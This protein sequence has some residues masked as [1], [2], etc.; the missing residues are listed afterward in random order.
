MED[1]CLFCKIA[2]KEISSDV[3]YEDD[4]I[5]AFNDI[6]PQAPVHIIFIPK[7]H[8][9]TLN[10]IS[11][12]DSDL[13]GRI[14]LAIKKIAFKKGISEDGYRIVANCNSN[15]GQEVFHVH[16]HLLGGRRCLWPPG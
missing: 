15:G 14:I 11:I 13:V 3:V 6:D 4:D 16:F 8:I 5:I 1:D 12:S 2:N 9:E 7:K 10:D